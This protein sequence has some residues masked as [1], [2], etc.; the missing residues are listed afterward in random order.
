MDEKLKNQIMIAIIP[1]GIV[2]VIFQFMRNIQP[3]G[4]G[5]LMMNFFLGFLIAAV[6]GG[7]TFGVVFMIQRDQ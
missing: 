4:T 1:A 6:I 5:S 2:F 3:A 7:I